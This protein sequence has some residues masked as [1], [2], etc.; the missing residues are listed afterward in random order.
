MTIG[1][2]AGVAR[3]LI[4]PVILA[5]AS[6]REDFR[7]R[8]CVTPVDLPGRIA[9]A[10]SLPPAAQ[11]TGRWTPLVHGSIC[12]F[13]AAFGK[14]VLGEGVNWQVALRRLAIVPQ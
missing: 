7:R 14:S 13:D 6:A 2:R 4:C 9:E 8:G 12:R 10:L 3:S 11:A 1:L 5:P